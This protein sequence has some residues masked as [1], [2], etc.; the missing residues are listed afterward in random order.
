MKRLITS[1]IL[2]YVAF[3]GFGQAQSSEANL[4]ISP[5]VNMADSS[6]RSVVEV[7]KAFLISKDSSFTSNVYWLESDFQ[8]YVYPYVDIYQ[9]GMSQFGPNFFQPSLMELVDVGSDEKLVKIGFVGVHPESNQRIIR[10][11]YNI[12]AV[13]Q[14]GV[15]KLK[16]SVDYQTRDWDVSIHK[17]LQYVLPKGKEVN[18]KEVKRQL[19][20]IKSLC[21][22]FKTSPIDITYY[23][24]RNVKQV[25]EVKGFDYLPNMY[26]TTKGGMA[27]TG[28]VVY[29]GNDSEFYTHEIVH[30]YTKKLF[31]TIHALLD[32]GMATWIGGSG[33]LDY[34]WHRRQFKAFLDT[35]AVNLVE[36]M[37]AY[38]RFDINRETSVPYMV[39]ALICERTIRLYGK[40]KLF[41]LLRQSEDIWEN[42]NAV[43]LNAENLQQE[44][45]KELAQPS[46][47]LK[48]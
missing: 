47:D 21:D 20:D 13:Q 1:L 34:S 36:H 7:V 3:L 30:V 29:S 8:R 17:S 24:C 6:N 10:A 9:I 39:G 32:E 25:F 38:E 40:E 45:L 4:S 11:V 27:E 19:K 41:N 22:F 48:S 18:R 28:N 16:R 2:F 12:I 43:G 23:S 37:E 46:L 14:N 5:A 42:L 44:L 33:G 15:W 35:S 31:P 26:F